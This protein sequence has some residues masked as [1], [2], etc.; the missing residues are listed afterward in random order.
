MTHQNLS[1]GK[2][3]KLFWATLKGQ[4]HAVLGNFST[5][6]MFIELTKIWKERFETIE[7]LKQNT[8]KQRRGMDGQNWGGLRWIAFG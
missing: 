5:D 7:E 6:Q 1:L 4:G 8:G 2:S 3:Q